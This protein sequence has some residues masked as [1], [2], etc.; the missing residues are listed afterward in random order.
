MPR[1]KHLVKKIAQQSTPTKSWL[2]SFSDI[3]NRVIAALPSAKSAYGVLFTL[4][5]VT[6]YIANASAQANHQMDDDYDDTSDDLY[7]DDALAAGNENAL[8]ADNNAPVHA[9]HEY[10][11]YPT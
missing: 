10:A 9:S 1:R 3:F 6:S 8:E 11:K 4:L 7:D 2:D 5:I